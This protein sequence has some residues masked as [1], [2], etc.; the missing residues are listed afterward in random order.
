MGV[1]KSVDIP[2]KQCVVT[3]ISNSNQYFKKKWGSKKGGR[4]M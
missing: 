2:I 3:T 1:K 4:K